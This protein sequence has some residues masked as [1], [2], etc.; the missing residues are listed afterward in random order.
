M[1]DDFPVKN[2]RLL[3]QLEV[4]TFSEHIERVVKSINLPLVQSINLPLLPGP[5]VDILAGAGS[6]LQ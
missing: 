1:H 2:G 6:E 5:I 4:H 3:L